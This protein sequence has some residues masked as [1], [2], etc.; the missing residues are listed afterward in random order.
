M[1]TPSSHQLPNQTSP[2]SY[3][4]ST[5]PDDLPHPSRSGREAYDATRPLAPEMEVRPGSSTSITSPTTILSDTSSDGP[6][7]DDRPM[8]A[9]HLMT[10]ESSSR[11][12]TSS[13]RPQSSATSVTSPAPS[14]LDGDD[15]VKNQGLGIDHHMGRESVSQTRRLPI[16]TP[17]SPNREVDS[18]DMQEDEF[19]SPYMGPDCSSLRVRPFDFAAVSCSSVGVRS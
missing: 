8:V 15:S 5:C 2:P 17:T 1:P 4:F 9:S 3:T 11:A 10:D 6:A 18:L 14:R 12:T 13:P 7:T 16:E 19:C